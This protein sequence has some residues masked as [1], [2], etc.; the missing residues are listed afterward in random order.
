MEPREIGQR[1]QAAR[2]RQH[3]TQIQFATKANVSPSS[4]ARWERGALP[5]VRELIRIAGILEVD[6]EELVEPAPTDEGQLALLREELA[7]VRGMVVRL[8]RDR[9]ETPPAAARTR[10]PAS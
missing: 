5:P 8:L 3:W 6:A 4:V 1:I 9:E 2:K 7:E 10:R